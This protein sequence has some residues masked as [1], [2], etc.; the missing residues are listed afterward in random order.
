MTTDERIHI[1]TVEEF[2]AHMLVLKCETED[3]LEEL[4]DC[5]QVHHNLKVADIFRQLQQLAEEG[6][7]EIE[8]LAEGVDLPVIAT[9]DHQWYFENS[10]EIACID[11]AYYL[12]N[13][14]QALELASFYSQRTCKFLLQ[15]MDNSQI[16]EVQKLARQ[17]LSYEQQFFMRKIEH[18]L[19]EVGDE[20]TPLCDDLD[21][22]N[23]PE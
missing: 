10:P 3:R 11:N 23:L 19:T 1:E 6:V 5:L 18:W 15:A 16:D 8:R 17:Q 7:C 20:D 9:W 21:P 4:A 13:R 14:R 12:M 2:L 22:P